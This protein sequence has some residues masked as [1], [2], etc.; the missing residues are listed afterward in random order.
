MCREQRTGPVRWW[1]TAVAILVVVVVVVVIAAYDVDA[2]T[3]RTGS[4]EPVL[5]E[6]SAARAF[7]DGHSA[8][9]AGDF[10][11]ARDAYRLAS[12]RASTEGSGEAAAL[13]SANALRAAVAAGDADE[14][15]ARLD[16]LLTP[17]PA[18]LQARLGL[19]AARTW[20]IAADRAAIPAREAESA[21]AALLRTTSAW[22]H[23]NAADRL[24][25]YADGYLGEVYE[26]R[27]R[28]TE[29]RQLTE[30]ALVTADRAGAT[31][32]I[33]RWY[34]QLGRIDRA[35]GNRE[36]ALRSMRRAVEILDGLRASRAVDLGG[37]SDAF[38]VAIRPVYLELFDLLLID[39]RTATGDEHQSLLSEARDTLEALGAAELRDYFDDPCLA[40]QQRVAA[41]RIPRT[42]VLYPVA[43]SDRLELITAGAD[44][45]SRTEVPIASADLRER[46][47]RLRLGL[48][49]R[50]SRRYLRD[51]RALYRLLIEPIGP[52]L[53]RE[54]VDTLVVVPMRSFRSI[55]FAAL[56]NPETERFLVEEIAVAIVPGMDL[57][58][59][60]PIAAQATDMLVAGISQSV[61]GLL[62]LPFV[63]EEV[64]EIHPLFEGRVL[65]D[66]DFRL[67]AFTEALAEHPFGIVHIA[68]HGEFKSRS[69]ESYVLAHDQKVSLEA[70]GDIV[71]RARRRVDHPIELLTL[72]ACSS[73]AGDD[74][75]ALGFAGVAVRSGARS[76]LATLWSI[77]DAATKRLVVRFYRE[78]ASGASRA[79]ALRQAQLSLIEDP[80]TRHA[81]HWAAFVLIASWL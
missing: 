31:E 56:Q 78:L 65:L 53:S 67:D 76:A 73:A 60:R 29:A 11:A 23:E 33:H 34:W 30:R 63:R 7:A 44:G 4:E 12:T 1:A 5:A 79:E 27:G 72:S 3:C 59:P 57:T 68:S 38:G 77:P 35:D 70:L 16:E 37:S 58:E 2:S 22:A 45:L 81:Y 71:S 75:A 74:R 50:T 54:H 28:L 24:A 69:G 43:L 47:R 6:A 26:R 32:A 64:A 66:A 49:N 8:F 41:D 13:A 21:A 55:P 39:A 46:V 36:R 80:S 18:G 25:S 62:P 9:E 40:S 19:H 17:A 20:L 42:L 15:Q 14:L 51:A 61:D 52:R 48:E 10:E